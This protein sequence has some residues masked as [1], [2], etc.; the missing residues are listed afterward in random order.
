MF[1]RVHIISAI[2][3]LNRSATREWL[4]MFATT[5]LRQYLDHLEVTLEPRG[6]GSR[7]VRA[8]ETPAVVTRD[9]IW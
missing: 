4:E 9:P 1:N 7:W 2:Q 3:Q 8:G 5:A 6:S